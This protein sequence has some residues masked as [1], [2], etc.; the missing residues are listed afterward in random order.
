MACMNCGKAGC[1]GAVVLDR[2]P[3]WEGGEALTKVV[4]HAHKGNHTADAVVT[5]GS[6][7]DG[8]SKQQ[9]WRARNKDRVR[10]NN[11]QYMKGRRAREGE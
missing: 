10:A 1:P 5:Q 2:C 8:L 6:H 11:Q 3:T 7:T 9:R 4:T